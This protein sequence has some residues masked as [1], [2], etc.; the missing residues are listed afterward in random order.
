MIEADGQCLMVLAGPL[1]RV[2]VKVTN[3]FT[4]L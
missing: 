4:Q 1:Y 3:E 2:L